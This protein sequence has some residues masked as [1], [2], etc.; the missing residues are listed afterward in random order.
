ML[1]IALSISALIGIFVFL[2]GDFGDTEIRLLVTT[3][4]IGGF[5]LTGLCSATIQYR[6]NLNPFSIIGMLISVIGF[7]ITL[8][9]IW[10]I[11]VFENILKT[12]LIFIIL[13]IATA[14][15]SLLLLITSKTGKLKYSLIGTIVFVSIVACMLIK[16]TITEFGES[17]FYFRLL[18]VFSILVV[19]GTIATPVLNKVTNKKE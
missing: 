3:V 15:I 5:S 13:S 4:T 2:V 16:S 10:E 9:T 6:N 8:L 1:V 17:E 18:G 11:F 7:F 14:H 12:M 19:L